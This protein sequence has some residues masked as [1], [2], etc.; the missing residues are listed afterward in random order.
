M[1]HYLGNKEYVVSEAIRQ[2]RNTQ[3]SWKYGYDSEFD[4][5]IISKDGT[6]GR[7]YNVNGIKIGLPE[8]PKNRKNIVNWDKTE[9]N[10]KWKRKD[11]PKG[12]TKDTQYDPK[13]EDYIKEE[14]RRRHEG[15]WVF[16]K[17]EKVYLT[18]LSYYLYQ[19]CYLD[20][21]YAQFR[22]IQNELM[23]FWEAC[24][25]DYRCYGV[26]YVKNRRFGWSTI[27]DAELLYSGTTNKD[28]KLG[29]VSKTN[30]DAK[31][32]FEIAMSMF[33]KLPPFFQPSWDEKTQSRII[34][35]ET[36]KSNDD[37]DTGL[38]SYIRYYTT[39]INSMDGGKK[40]FRS[41]LDEVGKF[42]KDVPFAKYWNTVRTS[43]RQGTRIVGKSMVGSTV[44]ALKNGGSEFKTVFDESDIAL[45]N[46]NGQTPSGLYQLFIS[47]ELGFEGRYDVY[48]FSIVDDPK[49]K[50][51]TDEGIY[52]T[53]G[54]KTFLDTELESKKN[55]PEGYNEHL[56]QFPRTVKH[57][58]R[59][60][61]G[62]CAFNL[63]KL[64]EQID[65]N[66]YE[67]NHNERGS[68]MIDRGNLVWKDGVIDSEVVWIPDP[69][70]GKF[71]IKSGCHPPKEYR[72]Q[73]EKRMLYG[74][75]AWAPIAEHIGC[76]GAD[77]YNRT[78]TSDGRGSLGALSLSTKANTSELPN[79]E[80]IVEYIDKAQKVEWFFEDA[81]MLAIYYSVPILGELSNEAFLKHI[82]DRG[83]RHFSMNNP[84]K[85]YN[86][87]S[88]TE[89][90][91]GG[92]PPQSDSIG[93]AQYM[94]VLAYV[95]DYI[96]VSDDASK[97]T[98]GTIGNMVFNRTLDHWKDVDIHNRQ[99]YD[100]YISSSLSLVG[101]Q[102]HL[103]KKAKPTKKRRNPF[104]TYNNSGTY[105]KAV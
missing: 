84:L 103:I 104:T 62:E 2:S 101:N 74:K 99:K 54:S 58:F 42:P 1:I 26:C 36:N 27:C 63:N 34:L 55:D 14:I 96:G 81:L 35:R 64:L 31:E 57:A 92:A 61:S 78:K 15:V 37:I 33:K 21:G 52:V 25:A 32:M 22:V 94:A 67:H 50:T 18:G 59:D 16:I 65:H 93:I 86:K 51:L 29:I 45:R 105:S 80:F 48:G 6:L 40:V 9:A 39:A 20:E 30:S 13:F 71:W 68:E 69:E 100:A 89:K 23:I 19:W 79:N 56:R 11:L 70:N 3:R 44:N 73:K 82:K 87:L 75:M 83:Y 7:I 10:Q 43:H 47:A 76:I 4:I 60:E 85:P 12:L 49:V 17:G 66:T 98:I 38:D 90:D 102:K 28:K 53:T 77:P 8:P 72:N 91:I 46:A 24:K 97:R 41:A 95:N 5:I 88:Y